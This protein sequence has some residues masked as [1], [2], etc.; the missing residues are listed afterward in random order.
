MLQPKAD[1]IW[2]GSVSDKQEFDD[3]KTRDSTIKTH[4]RASDRCET[5]Q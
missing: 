2:E 4:I 3:I 5:T 1:L